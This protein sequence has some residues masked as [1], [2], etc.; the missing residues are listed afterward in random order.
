[1]DLCQDSPGLQHG[2]EGFQPLSPQPEAYLEFP[3]RHNEYAAVA[4]AGEFIDCAVIVL[5]ALH[6]GE[7]HQALRLPAGKRTVITGYYVVGFESGLGRCFPGL[8]QSVDSS[9]RPCALEH[10]AKQG[11][12][13]SNI[14][15]RTG[16]ANQ[17]ESLPVFPAPVASG[18]LVCSVSF[19]SARLGGEYQA[20][21]F[22]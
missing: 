5:K 16:C 7:F 20:A 3:I 11:I 4:N 12:P 17:L 2:A 8:I 10:P 1:M 14:Q 6:H 18:F 22:R 15:H 9:V 19:T 13:S 21:A